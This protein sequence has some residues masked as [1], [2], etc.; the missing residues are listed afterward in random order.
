MK[1]KNHQFT[2]YQAFHANFEDVYIY[3]V[4][5]LYY[6]FRESHENFENNYIMFGTKDVIEGWLYGCVQA[7]HKF[8]TA[9]AEILI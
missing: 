3:K 1:P 6:V 5:K 7:N 9:R 2:N 8:V 4:G